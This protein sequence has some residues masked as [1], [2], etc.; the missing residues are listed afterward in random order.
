MLFLETARHLKLKKSLVQIAFILLLLSYASMSTLRAYEYNAPLRLWQTSLLANPDNKRA[1]NSMGLIMMRQGNINGADNAF[2]RA[3]S[4]D[5][6]YVNA[7]VNSGVIH[8]RKGEFMNAAETF[9]KALEIKPADVRIIMNTGAAFL[10]LGDIRA[11]DFYSKITPSEPEYPD[12]LFSLGILYMKNGNNNKAEKYFLSA[13][14]NKPEN[15]RYTAAAG[16]FLCRT[17]KTAEGLEL[18]H[19]ALRH[20][21]E[22]RKI[23]FIIRK[24]SPDSTTEHTPPPSTDHAAS[25]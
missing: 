8:Y 16:E 19:K 1:W 25:P 4:I 7:L 23:M 22:N 24:Y 10:A 2:S 14:K 20:S 17:G 18:L 13:M 15:S 11:A 3:L 9:I 6:E 21:P 5:P 12:A